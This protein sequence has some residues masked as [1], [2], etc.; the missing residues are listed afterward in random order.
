MKK[1][2][3]NRTMR[4]SLLIKARVGFAHNPFTMP[5]NAYSFTA[6]STIT[7]LTH[8]QLDGLLQERRARGMSEERLAEFE[9]WHRAALA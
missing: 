4:V 3:R 7:V 9:A 2:L 5:K 1:T 6:Q 8:A